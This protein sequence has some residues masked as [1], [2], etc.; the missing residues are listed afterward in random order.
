MDGI[1]RA[2][3]HAEADLLG[4]DAADVAVGRRRAGQL[5]V[6]EILEG[7]ASLLEARRIDVGYVVAEDVHPDLVILQA[8]DAGI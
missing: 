4:I 5:L 8:C 3:G 6:Q 1:D 2:D 7:R